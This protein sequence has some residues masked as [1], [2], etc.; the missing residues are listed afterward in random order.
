MNYVKGV[1]AAI[2]VLIILTLALQNLAAVE[3]SF[4][5]W[6]ISLPKIV[7]ILMVYVFGMISGWG[8]VELIKRWAA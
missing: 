1:I 7:L 5:F 3:V 2:I 8:L 4:L 6:S